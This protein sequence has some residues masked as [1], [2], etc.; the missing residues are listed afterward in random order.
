MRSAVAM[1]QALASS[2]GAMSDKVS[3]NN[4]R[5]FGKSSGDM[6]ATPTCAC[7]GLPP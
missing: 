1:N 6:P 3:E 4:A 2:L 5:H 7:T